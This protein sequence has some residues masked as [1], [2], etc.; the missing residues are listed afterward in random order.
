MRVTLAYPYTAKDGKSY[1]PDETVELPDVEAV[2]LLRNGRARRPDEA[3]LARAEQPAQQ[4]PA[5]KSS[6][7][8]APQAAP[9]QEG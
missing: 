7:T 4:A 9:K 5:D 3:D 6:G 1:Q 8:R 2:K